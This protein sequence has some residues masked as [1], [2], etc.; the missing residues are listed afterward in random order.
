MAE[1]VV[2]A[3]RVQPEVVMAVLAEVRAESGASR[4]PLVQAAA[5]REVQE[6]IAMV[7]QVEVAHLTAGQTHQTKAE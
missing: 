7:L 6:Q 5:I 1:P 2:P 3:E 4:V